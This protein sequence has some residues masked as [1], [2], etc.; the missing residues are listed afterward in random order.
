MLVLVT[1]I[2]QLKVDVMTLNKIIVSILAAALINL[3]SGNPETAFAADSS[4]W[5][6]I[7]TMYTTVA[8]DS[9]GPASPMLGDLDEDGD[10]DGVDLG[11][12]SFCLENQDLYGDLDDNGTVTPGDVEL[13][14]KNYGA[15]YVSVSITVNG[16]CCEPPP[17]SGGVQSLAIEFEIQASSRSTLPSDWWVTAETPGG[18]TLYLHQE[19]W[20]EQLGTFSQAVAEVS[21][22]PFAAPKFELTQ[23]LGLYTFIFSIDA[24]DDGTQDNTW[25]RAVKVQVVE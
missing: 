12:L 14:T 21:A 2:G 20:S 22:V 11:D 25:L 24:N 10:V 6:S 15:T 8:S 7:E 5:S 18:S 17:V 23:G 9:T 4:L 16:K 19:G 1:L 13:F 3:V